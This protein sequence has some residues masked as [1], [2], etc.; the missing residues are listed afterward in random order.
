[1]E[2]RTVNDLRPAASHCEGLVGRCAIG[3]AFLKAR[4]IA[5]PMHSS[6][7]AEPNRG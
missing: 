1:M 5:Q 6:G 4:V 7:C 2:A 3:R